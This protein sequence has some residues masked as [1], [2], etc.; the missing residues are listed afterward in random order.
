MKNTNKTSAVPQ[1]LLSGMI[2]NG[3]FKI[4]DALGNGYTGFVRSGMS[5]I[6]FCIFL[7]V[8]KLWW[9]LFT[10]S[11]I[12]RHWYENRNIS[13]YQICKRGTVLFIRKWIQKL[14]VLG[15]RW[16]VSAFAHIFLWEIFF[17]FFFQ[18]QLWSFFSS[19]SLNGLY[20]LLNFRNT[21]IS[22][23][24]ANFFDD[25]CYEQLIFLVLQYNYYH[26]HIFWCNRIWG[27]GR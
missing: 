18:W 1:N 27:R 17:V 19:Y 5:Y 4:G 20:G 16:Y 24:L 22:A 14:P 2:I 6:N 3:R 8:D 10:I 26:N 9:N 21:H 11:T 25:S 13:S 15:C 12:F 7:L 23:R